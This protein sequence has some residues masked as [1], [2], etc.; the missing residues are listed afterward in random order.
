MSYIVIQEGKNLRM[1]GASD[2]ILHVIADT[3]EEEGTPY[4]LNGSGSE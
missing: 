2:E 3:C 1:Y 4:V